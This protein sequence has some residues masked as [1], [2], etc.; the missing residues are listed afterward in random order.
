M[1]W[2]EGHHRKQRR[3]SAGEKSRQYLSD[4][5]MSDNNL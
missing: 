2:L 3:Q 5:D 4:D 1:K